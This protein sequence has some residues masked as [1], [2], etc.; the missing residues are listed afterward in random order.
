MSELY[1]A[2]QT[3]VAEACEGGY[4]QMDTLK[5][6]EVQKNIAETDHVYEFVGLYINK[7][8]YDSMSAAAQK[9]IWHMP[10]SWQRRIVNSTRKIA[11]TVA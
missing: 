3:K 9:K 6:Y 10:I 7:D 1:T 8:L 5:L 4:E 11:L 2:L